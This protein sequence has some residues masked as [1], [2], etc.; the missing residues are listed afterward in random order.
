M[1]CHASQ[2]KS[3]S[4]PTANRNRGFGFEREVVNKAREEGLEAE[5][6][7]GSN[8]KSL[9]ETEGVDCLVAGL[10]VQCKRR[11]KLASYLRL[12]EGCDAVVFREDRGATLAM[13]PLE[14][15]FQLL[16]PQP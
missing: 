5:R 4:S 11:K 13:I 10:R 8:G 2:T 3:M 9:G 14:T 15:L 1:A 6:A 7:W 16:Q 12:P